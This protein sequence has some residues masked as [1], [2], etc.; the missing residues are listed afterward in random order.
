ML[1]PAAVFAVSPVVVPAS[2]ALVRASSREFAV[3]SW[4]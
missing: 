3:S 2:V 1:I 4:I